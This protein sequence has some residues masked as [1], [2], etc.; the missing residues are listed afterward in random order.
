LRFQPNV[1]NAGALIYAGLAGL[2][3]A[4]IWNIVAKRQAGLCCR[5]VA[6]QDKTTARSTDA[7]KRWPDR[8]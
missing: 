7:L 4:S 8:F 1:E 2:S 3:V 6:L 5:P